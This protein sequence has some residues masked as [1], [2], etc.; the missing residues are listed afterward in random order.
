[1][2]AVLVVTIIFR[3]SS[4]LASAYGIAVTCTMVLTTMIAFVLVW[5]IWHWPVW[6]AV[7]V[8]APL[9]I[10]ELTF[11]AAN[12][13]KILE[14]GWLP[15]L[16]AAV[17]FMVMTTW[18]RGARL[19]ASQAAD[20]ELKWLVDKLEAKPPHRVPGTAV[21][22]TADAH[23][24]PTALMHNLKHN[25]II[26]ERNLIV[27]I[28]T[29]PRPRVASAD[30]IRVERLSDHFIA[31]AAAYGFMEAPNIPR[32]L[33]DCRKHGLNVE[34]GGIS[35]FLSR[36]RLKEAPRSEMARWQELLFIR[37]SAL[38]E[39]ASAYFAIPT[40]R[41]IEVGTQSRI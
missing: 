32:L 12:A 6:K 40:D 25:N 33:G 39:D 34:S 37:L 31:V 30:R 38:A 29:S 5:R 27:S 1:M 15:L 26:H 20:V 4:A 10:V 11:A 28:T 13:V 16:I 2:V 7:L 23:W 17:T 41:V 8:L 9:L 22:L 19:L 36:R 21:F 14:G 35:Y 3:S 24:A 18:K